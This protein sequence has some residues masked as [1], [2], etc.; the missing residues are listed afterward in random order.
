M[1]ERKKAVRKTTKYQEHKWIECQFPL[2][3]RYLFGHSV[4]SSTFLL[5]VIINNIITVSIK[6]AS[7]TFRF[8]MLLLYASM[9]F[10]S[11]I[12]LTPN[13]FVK[14][15]KLSVEKWHS[16]VDCW[17]CCCRCVIL[18][19]NIDSSFCGY[20]CCLGVIGWQLRKMSVVSGFV[21]PEKFM[22]PEC[23][24][25]FSVDSICVYRTIDTHS[26]P[27]N[28]DTDT[29]TMMAWKIESPVS[30]VV[31]CHHYCNNIIALYCLPNFRSTKDKLHSAIMEPA[32]HIS[33]QCN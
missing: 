13:I 1:R 23:P 21:W 25:V 15:L 24:L 11:I 14:L 20:I 31:K 28:I 8:A 26:R 32:P 5:C 10:L 30:I 12:I 6:Y 27:T 3:T 9:Q 22:D 29:N 4:V 16:G 19:F 17:Y 7:I 33:G 2:E 18:Y